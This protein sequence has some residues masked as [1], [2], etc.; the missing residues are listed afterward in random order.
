MVFLAA[1]NDH[2]EVT[3][4]LKLRYTATPTDCPFRPSVDVLF[5]SAGAVW[6]RPGIAVLLTGMGSDGAEGFSRLRTL[7]WHTIAQDEATCVVYGMPKAAVE[8]GAASEV[9]PIEHI[10]PTVVARILQRQ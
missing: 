2:L 9:L 8:R 4:D 7:G 6:P 3:P 5:S 10:G 1:S